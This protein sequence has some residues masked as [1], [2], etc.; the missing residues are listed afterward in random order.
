ME[1]FKNTITWIP[2]LVLLIWLIQGGALALVIFF[3]MPQIIV[4]CN[5]D[6]EPENWSKPFILQERVLRPREVSDLSRSNS[7]ALC[8]CMCHADPTVTCPSFPRIT[9]GHGVTAWF[10]CPCLCGAF[11]NLPALS[12]PGQ[13]AAFLCPCSFHNDSLYHTDW[14]F[15][16]SLL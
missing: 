5:Q 16:L 12:L 9:P 2:P 1:P 11:S 10:N 7:Q 14:F 15:R 4:T 8:H 13:V 3:K 6:W